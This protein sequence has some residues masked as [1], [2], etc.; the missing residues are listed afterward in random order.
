M[1]HINPLIFGLTILVSAM[2]HSAFQLKPGLWEVQTTTS[3]DGKQINAG[4]KMNE[5]MQKMSPA[6]RKQMEKMMGSKGVGFGE[7]GVKVCHATATV[8]DSIVN[9]PKNNCEIKDKKELSDGVKFN[10]QCKN[11]SGTAEYHRVSDTSYKGFNEFQ[12]EKGS[13]RTEFTGKFV[14]SDCGNVK[15]LQKVK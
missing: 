3:V 12:T 6:Q 4:Q 14:S 10:I 11:G 8:E 15:P 9:D 5:A 13:S 2:A 1:Q 7:N